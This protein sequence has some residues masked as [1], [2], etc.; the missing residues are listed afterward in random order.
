MEKISLDVQKLID[1]LHLPESNILEMFAFKLDNNDLTR[2]EAIKFIQF[3][4]SELA[5]R[6]Q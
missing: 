4:R 1:N 6:S 3:L 5:N 2:E